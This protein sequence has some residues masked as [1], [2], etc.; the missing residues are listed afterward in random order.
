MRVMNKNVYCA[1]FQPVLEKYTLEDTNI[2][3]GNPLPEFGY[4]VAL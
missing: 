1:A 2:G 3:R 4:M